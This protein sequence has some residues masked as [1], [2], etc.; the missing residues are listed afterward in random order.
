MTVGWPLFRSVE[1]GGEDDYPIIQPRDLAGVFLADSSALARVRL[2]RAAARYRVAE[3]DLV[4]LNRGAAGPTKVSI[5]ASGVAGAIATSNLTLIRPQHHVLLGE[6]LLAYLLSTS[7]QAELQRRSA[8][9]TV[10]ALTVDQLGSVRVPVPHR[11][12][13]ERI[14]ALWRATEGSYV[15]AIAAAEDRRTLGVAVLDQLFQSGTAPR[16]T[17]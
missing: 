7:G 17:Q 12:T 5:V 13:Q 14:V 15:E 10:R 11:A 8:T 6:A 3:G 1:S 2:P 16:F 9:S 4:L